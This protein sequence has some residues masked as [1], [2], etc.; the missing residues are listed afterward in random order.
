MRWIAGGA[1]LLGAV[2]CLAAAALRAAPAARVQPKLVL[3]PVHNDADDCAIWI[4]PTDPARSTVIGNDKA[5]KTSGLYVYDLSKAVVQFVPMDR[6]SNLDVRYGMALGGRPVDICAAVDRK[7]NRIKVF[8]IDPVSRKLRD[9]TAPGGIPSHVAK[10]TYG[11]ALYRRPADGAVFAFA[12]DAR[13]GAIAQ[14]RLTDDGTGKVR[15]ALVRRLGRSV[16]RGSVEG[17]VA[18]DELGFLYA[19]DEDRAVL[20]FHADPERGAEP[21]ARFALRDGIAGDREGLAL[22]PCADG[23]GYLVLS[24]QGNNTVKVYAREGDNRFLK[25]IDTVGARDTDG[26]DVTPCPAGPTFPHGFMVC[27]NSPGRQFVLYAWEDV[28]GKEL[29]VRSD[30]NPR[31]AGR[32][33]AASR[34]TTP[35][36]TRAR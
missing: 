14:V 27:H 12:S 31:R 19:A 6:P 22:Y 28:A 16:I 10:D 1:L 23:T 29:K 15:G 9:V 7:R 35:A 24:S 21:V 17:M 8:A 30:Y 20:K 26:L 5:G 11:L 36:E 33:P 32:R 18:D 25:T 2:L 13:A 34:A 4:H 3:P